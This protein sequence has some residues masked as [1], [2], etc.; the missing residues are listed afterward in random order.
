MKR[1]IFT[2]IFVVGLLMCLF[3]PDI[4]TYISTN[5]VNELVFCILITLFGGAGLIV[6]MYKK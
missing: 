6:D 5:E 2:I 3:A 1:R 4:F